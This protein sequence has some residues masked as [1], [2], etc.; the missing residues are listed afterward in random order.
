MGA[1]ILVEAEAVDR[2]TELGLSVPLLERVLRRAD[3]EVSTCTPLDPPIMAGLTRWGRTAR[4]LREELVPE[5]WHFDNPRNLPRTIHPSGEFAIVAI[6]GNELTGA[7]D[8]LPATK[9]PRGPATALA[10][11]ANEQM[12]FDFDGFDF[13]LATGRA[14]DTGFL[15]TWF[16]LFHVHDEAFHVEVSLPDAITDGRITSW[17]ERIIVPPFPRDP[18]AAP[19][20]PDLAENDIVVEVIRR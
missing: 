12:T 10:I 8:V 4:Y 1:R 20:V 19:A 13:G 17:A 3:A 5:G 18:A 2:L 16:L 6:T 15:L 7:L 14:L 9:N 11:A